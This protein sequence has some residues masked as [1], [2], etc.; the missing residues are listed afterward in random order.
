MFSW[1]Y[2]TLTP[3]TARLFRLLGVHPGPDIT[4]PA[5]ASLA[6]CDPGTTRHALDELTRAHLIIE[7]APGRYTL[8]DLLRAYAA[9]QVHL[10]DD[11]AEQQAALRRLL[12]FYTHTACGA[13]LLLTPHRAPLP[14]DPPAPGVHLRPL[15][16]TSAALDWY[17]AEHANLLAA[18]QAAAA[19]AWHPTVWQL[20]CSLV[21]FHVRRGHRH[22]QIVVWQ[23]A[24]DAT[25][26][27]S[28]PW[29]SMLAHRRLGSAVIEVGRHDEGIAHLHQ[30]LAL[31]EKHGDLDQQAQTHRILA[32]AWEQ[33][34]NER[35]SLEHAAATL[36]LA[37]TLGEPMR[38]AEA[39]NQTGWYLAQLGEFDAAGTHCEAALAI[40]RRH[41]HRAGEAGTL[42][43]LGYIAHHRGHHQQAVE[44]CQEALAILAPLGD[45]FHTADVLD[46]LG[47]P[48]AAL[49]RHEQ[50]RAAW[51][52]ALELY[53]QQGRDQAADRVRQQLDTLDHPQDRHS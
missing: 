40:H 2:H 1:S 7:H 20:A 44:Y 11:A 46:T 27:L 41:N 30:S 26:R 12:D 49:G 25:D 34:H 29:A 24:L 9:E 8:H 17:D 14:L 32:W 53:R 13:E 3:A 16:D 33:Q 4:L 18:Q 51:R 10:H 39:L 48:H 6:G 45:V 22:D 47:H 43:S 19:H 15:P 38:E 35:Q 5:A 52:Q 50:A 36:N 28:D 31:A 21:T 23:A 42:D 37:R